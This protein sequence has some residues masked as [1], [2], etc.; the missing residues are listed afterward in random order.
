MD[1]SDCLTAELSEKACYRSRFGGF[2]FGF[3][4]VAKKAYINFIIS[5]INQD[6]SFQEHLK[7]ITS[8]MFYSAAI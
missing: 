3:L 7:T 2:G 4:N 5:F 8:P 6:T 1:S